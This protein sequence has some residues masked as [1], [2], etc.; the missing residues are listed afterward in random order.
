MASVRRHLRRPSAAMIVAL[1]ALFVAVDG[2]AFAVHQ[3]NGRVLKNRSVS[4]TKLKPH[5]VPANRLKRGAVVPGAEAIG[6]LSLG[7]LVNGGSSF[8]GG[9]DPDESDAKV[10]PCRTLSI[11]QPAKSNVLVM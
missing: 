4:G 10:A 6:G 1:V 7:Q 5:S 3:I 9:C 2:P 8:H 11:G